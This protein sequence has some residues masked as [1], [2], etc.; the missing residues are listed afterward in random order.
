M[1]SIF[2]LFVAVFSVGVMWFSSLVQAA[3]LPPDVTIGGNVAP[4]TTEVTSTASVS[5]M[6]VKALDE[7]HVRATFSDDMDISSVRAKL[8]KQSDGT[9]IRVVSLTG[10][11]DMSNAVDITLAS[12]IQEGSAYVLT[13]IS[14]I[15]SD[16]R[17]IKD[18]ALAIKD[19]ITPVPLKKAEMV[20]N[21]PPNPN[22]AIAPSLSTGTTTGA[23]KTVTTPITPIKTGTGGAASVSIAKELPLTGMNPILLILFA[24]AIT[25]FLVRR[26]A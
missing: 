8:T 22:V 2:S 19:F 25:Y 12:N 10:V 17:A 4:A 7:L 16:G 24:F 13:I 5:V 23:V 26:K 6:S 11:T 15:T 1:K 21:A 9:A 3:I 14:G 20:L 18:G